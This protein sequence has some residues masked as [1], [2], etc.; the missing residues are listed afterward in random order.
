MTVENDQPDRGIITTSGDN[1]F[2]L[3]LQTIGGGGSWRSQIQNQIQIQISDLVTNGN[4]G[5]VD[6]DG[7]GAQDGMITTSGAGSKSV[8]LQT[9]GGGGGFA[10]ATDSVTGQDIQTE[11][12]QQLQS[13]LNGSSF[14]GA[15]TSDGNDQA[16]KELIGDIQSSGVV[17]TSVTGKSIQISADPSST[18]IQEDIT[19]EFNFIPSVLDGGQSWFSFPVEP[20]GP[21]SENLTEY[22]DQVAFVSIE[23]G[24]EAKAEEGYNLMLLFGSQVPQ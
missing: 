6:V 21:I 2:G 19:D 10:S 11:L 13:L 12:T 14:I 23:G 16:I 3:L 4:G 5:S 7:A 15:I 9:V 24:I 18:L 17:L 22:V 1:S 8:V 20:G